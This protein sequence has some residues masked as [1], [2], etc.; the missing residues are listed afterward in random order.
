MKQTIGG[1]SSAEEASLIVPRYLLLASILQNK[2]VAERRRS[3]QP[4]KSCELQ[5]SE[6]LPTTDCAIVDSVHDSISV[7]RFCKAADASEFLHALQQFPESGSLRIILILNMTEAFMESQWPGDIS[8]IDAL[9]ALYGFPPL[10]FEQLI[11]NTTRLAQSVLRG[12]RVRRRYIEKYTEASTL[13][14]EYF[15][16]DQIDPSLLSLSFDAEMYSSTRAP[17]VWLGVGSESQV[18][19]Q[20]SSRQVDF[21]SWAGV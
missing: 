2:V 8:I 4:S 14:R 19:T 12:L 3:L 10:F 15:V 21:D 16:T 13:E 6:Q 9:G 11:S 17:R 18:R 1:S 20:L 7:Q 5:Q